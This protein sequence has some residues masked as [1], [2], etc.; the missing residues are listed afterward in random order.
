LK[1]AI[2]PRFRG[3]EAGNNEDARRKD[4][5]DHYRTLSWRVLPRSGETN[6][7]LSKMGLKGGG[8]W[9]SVRAVNLDQLFRS[10]TT[11]Y[12]RRHQA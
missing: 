9:L 7:G 1:S 3:G 4:S 10:G 12:A 11:T 8:K 2:G 6:V 5:L